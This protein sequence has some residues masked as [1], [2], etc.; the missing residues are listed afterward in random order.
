MTIATDLQHESAGSHAN[1]DKGKTPPPPPRQPKRYARAPLATVRDVSR[2]LAT[3]YREARSER[4]DLAD[5]CR[6]AYILSILQRSLSDAELEDR[7]A[8]LEQ[9]RLR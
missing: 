4:I 8:A 1:I 7:V 9:A 3:L 6:L 2:Q 5:A